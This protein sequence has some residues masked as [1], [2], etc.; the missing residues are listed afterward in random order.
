MERESAMAEA[1][2]VFTTISPK[3]R[4]VELEAPRN[5]LAAG[6]RDR[7][8]ALQVS[9][10]YGVVTLPLIGDATWQAWRDL[11]EHPS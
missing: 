2:P 8:R 1:V 4:R 6:S 10:L 7:R 3:V 9:R 11:V 5:W